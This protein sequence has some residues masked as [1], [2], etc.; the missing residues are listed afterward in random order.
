MRTKRAADKILAVFF[1]IMLL[2]SLFARDLYNLT[3]PKVATQMV[4]KKVIPS[5]VLGPDGEVFSTKRMA[6]VIPR[7]A[8]HMGRVYVL[9]ETKEGT[10][11]S[12]RVVKTGE[13]LEDLVEVTEGLTGK[14]KV[15]IGSD[16][17]VWDQQQVIETEWNVQIAFHEARKRPSEQMDSS[18]LSKCM[19]NNILLLIILTVSTV[20]VVLLCKKCCRKR[21]RGIRGPMLILWCALVCLVIRRGIVIPGEWIPEKLIDWNG[22][23]K[24][25]EHYSD[26]QSLI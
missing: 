19:R 10:F 13:M 5:E 2:L 26:F 14:T 4:V 3:L 18:Y 12:E 6:L 20:A 21:L 9:T 23:I 24:N 22:W 7:K 8:L 15:L 16:R 25:I 17:E 1:T 11:L